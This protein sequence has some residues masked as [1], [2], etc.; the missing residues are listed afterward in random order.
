[1]V[2]RLNYCPA[3]E[4]SHVAVPQ[5][6][7]VQSGSIRMNITFSASETNTDETRLADIIHACG[8]ESDLDRLA[9]GVE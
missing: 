1:M 7:W 6:A 2:C 9:D 5:H 3:S 8:L 4:Q